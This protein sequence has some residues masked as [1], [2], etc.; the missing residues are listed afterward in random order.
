MISMNDLFNGQ[1]KDLTYE[2]KYNKILDEEQ[3]RCDRYNNALG[4]LH[5]KDSIECPVCKNKG[6]KLVV[7]HPE[8]GFPESALCKCPN[9]WEARQ[10]ARNVKTSG[11]GA[12][13]GLSFDHYV[14]NYQWQ[15]NA[16]DK[17][18][19]YAIHIGNPQSAKW[20]TAVG[21]VGSGKTMLA[22]CIA[23]ELLH[24]GWKVKMKSWPEVARYTSA[25][26]YK[27]K[28]TLK[29]YQEAPVLYLD[30]LFKGSPTTRE[31]SM[32]YEIINHRYK[33]NMPT[34]ITSE[35]TPDE[36]IAID[37]AIWSRIH[38]MSAPNGLVVIGKDRGKDQRENGSWATV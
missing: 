35:K 23:N 26:Y 7:I 24:V 30:D 34:I 37:E 13:Y 17:A 33:N 8:H 10:A 21:Q 32:A 28:E 3:A 14:I 12:D 6:W 2:E 18:K 16:R 27:E 1:Q 5:L 36:M 25:D 19:E 4:K 15:K 20:F 31:I 38:Q 29:E 11:I 22:S 9:C